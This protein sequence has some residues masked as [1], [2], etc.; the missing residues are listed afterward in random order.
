MLS[1]A[2]FGF[3]GEALSSIA[4]VAKVELLS[5]TQDAMIGSRYCIEGGKELAFEEVG[6]PTGTTILV[7][8]LFFNTPAR[9]KF[10][11]TP[12]TEA[13]A[14]A[15]FME[16]LA[17]SHP[18]VSIKFIHNG[19]QRLQT[20][21]N[22][23]L[24][25]IVY[26]IYGR[27]VAAN[28]LPV[29]ASFDTFSVT[30]RIGKPVISRG[31]RNFESYFI[32][33]RYI[34]SSL[35]S[36]AIE[37]GYGGFLMQHKYPFVVLKLT[38]DGNLV[39]VNVHPNKMQLRFFQ[40]EA[41]YRDISRLI[42]DT[43]AGRELIAEVA[44][45]EEKS[46]EKPVL[47]EQAAPMQMPEEKLAETAPPVEKIKTPI[48]P[49]PFEFY[50][51]KEVQESAAAA[52]E[53]LLLKEEIKGAFQQNLS[54]YLSTQNKLL[55]KETAKQHRII[56]QL[57]DT[58]WL[59]EFDEKFYMIDQ[60]AAHEKVL[61]EKMLAQYEK[62]EFTS[63]RISPPLILSLSMQEE[64]LLQR[65][66]PRFEALGFEI[67]SFGGKEYAV[68]AVPG[69][70][71]SLN[72][73]ELLLELID[74]LGSL[75]EKEAPQLVLEKLA[76]MS[77]KAAVKGS[78]RLSTQEAQALISDL[79]QLE[80]PYFCPHGRPVIISMTKYEIEKKFKRIV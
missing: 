64:Q 55:S 3:R 73:K 41:L 51:R 59:V 52:K 77:C 61:Y 46:E 27:E 22:G 66:L 75:S 42:H 58:Y 5:K 1:I 71:Y 53:T 35:L 67:A 68:S 74:S 26:Q 18:D 57:F 29:D 23:E 39:D 37:D 14:I 16:R 44:V 8:D 69:N 33:G 70:L 4:A 28:L 10:L 76:S 63:Q 2:S 36:K 7:K 6:V 43:L 19:Q 15:D 79:L 62:K 50:R 34:K 80:N 17:L 21:G 65:H 49:E 54:D 60:H 24:K 31:N 56:G 48:P 9:H 38:M 12:Q 78:N 40:E 30:G 72:S 11:K 20:S 32:N 13:A 45:K 25:D 47:K